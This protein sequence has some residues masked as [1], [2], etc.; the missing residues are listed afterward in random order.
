MN[1]KMYLLQLMSDLKFSPKY[2]GHMYLEAIVDLIFHNKLYLKSLSRYVYPQI[3]KDFNTAPKSVEKAV[4]NAIGHA[5]EKGGLSE[6]AEGRCPANKEVI[7]YLINK[8]G[9]NNV[10]RENNVSVLKYTNFKNWYNLIIDKKCH[11]K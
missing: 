10:R 1:Y 7:S 11:F 3:A 5:F 8:L 9:E 6:I 2:L 4:E